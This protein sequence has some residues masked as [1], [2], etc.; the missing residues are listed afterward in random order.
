VGLP[1][2]EHAATTAPKAVIAH[3]IEVLIG[4]LQSRMTWN[5]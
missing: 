2:A 1:E 5:S 4:A 3:K